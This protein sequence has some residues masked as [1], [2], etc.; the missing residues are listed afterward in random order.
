VVPD[1]IVDDIATT[2]KTLPEF[3][4]LWEQMRA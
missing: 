4:A 2:A 1:V 3:P